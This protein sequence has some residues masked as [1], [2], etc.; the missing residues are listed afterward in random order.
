MMRFPHYKQPDAMD[1]GSC[2]LKMIAAYYGRDY[3]RDILQK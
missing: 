3:T 1:C 2:C